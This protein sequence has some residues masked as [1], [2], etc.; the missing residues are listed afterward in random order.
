VVFWAAMRTSKYVAPGAFSLSRPQIRLDFASSFVPCPVGGRALPHLILE[1]QSR[2]ARDEQSNNFA[3]SCQRGL[4]N[5][6][7][8]RMTPDRIVPA[9]L[10][11]GVQ[12]QTHDFR[13]PELRAEGQCPVA[14][15]TTCRRQQVAD[16]GNPPERGRNWH[17]YL[18][19]MADQRMQCFELAKGCG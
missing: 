7:R 5:G 1:I 10:F 6:R 2:A 13:V 14:V 17:S 19:P 3:G 9:W 15:V 18:G 11:T 4:M 12:Q 16:V 8:G